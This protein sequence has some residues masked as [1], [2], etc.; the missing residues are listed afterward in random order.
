MTFI[1]QNGK[2]ERKRQ[3]IMEISDGEIIGEDALVYERNQS[4]SVQVKSF[5]CRLYKIEAQEF[6]KVFSRMIPVLTDLFNQ[7]FSFMNIRMNAN[8]AQ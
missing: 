2:I 7:R 6:S 5:N 3:N 4:Y 1:N 8:R